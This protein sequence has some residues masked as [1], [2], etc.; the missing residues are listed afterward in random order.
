MNL[1]NFT[2]KAAEVFQQAQQLAFNARN[3]NIETEHLLKALLEQQDSPV[4]YL[5]KKNNVTV[6]VLE[7]KLDELIAKLPSTSGDPAQSISRDANNV[8]L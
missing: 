8:I 6:N 7:T 5:L 4:E 2:I 1:G 3:P